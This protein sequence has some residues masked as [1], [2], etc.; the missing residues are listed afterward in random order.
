V[1]HDQGEA[2]SM[3]HRIAVFNEGRIAQVGTPQEVYHR[4]ASRFVAGFV[5]ASNIL[6]PDFVQAQTG[7]AAPASLRPEAIRIADQGHAATVTAATFMGGNTRLTLDM[8]GQRLTLVQ[9]SSSPLP[10]PGASVH[11]AWPPEALHIMDADA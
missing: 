3:A 1:T 8:N 9:P 7:Q 5:G 6:E 2:L 4:P 10:Q 11:V